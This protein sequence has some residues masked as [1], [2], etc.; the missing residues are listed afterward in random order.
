[1]RSPVVILLAFLWVVGGSGFI[2]PARADSAAAYPGADADLQLIMSDLQ[3]VK[4]S[5]N[6]F[7]ERK[8]LRMLSQPLESSGTL[9]YVAPDHL[10]K[11]TERPQPETLVVDGQSLV[12][13]GDPG[14]QARTLA[15]PDNPEIWA[16]VEGIRATLAGDLPGLSRFYAVNLQGNVTDWKLRLEPRDTRVQAMVKSMVMSGHNGQLDSIETFEAD[17]D[18]SVMTV[19]PG[20]P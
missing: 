3:R 17:G 4:T 6:K 2:V 9:I 18:R 7:V 5:Q 1:M 19:L 16:L 10:E 14:G 11:N 8:Y 12:I 20:R 15:L 13:G